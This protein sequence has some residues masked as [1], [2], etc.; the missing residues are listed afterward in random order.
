M[1]TTSRLAVTVIAAVL[2]PLFAPTASHAAGHFTLAFQRQLS[3][4]E[5]SAGEGCIGGHVVRVWVWD[6][7]GNPMSLI[8]LKTTWGVLMGATDSDGRAE[9]PLNLNDFD[10]TCVD[11][12]GSTSDATRLMTA[13][14]P[15]CWGHY[16]FEVGF[17]YKTD[18]S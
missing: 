8:D 17:L 1:T 2:L 11:N 6:E 10:L 16:S 4:W 9:I 15:E 7:N 12:N 14:R 18:V 13:H 3:A 5:N